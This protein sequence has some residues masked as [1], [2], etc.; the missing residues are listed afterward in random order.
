MY[1]HA[2]ACNRKG[3]KSSCIIQV[4]ACRWLQSQV[5]GDRLDLSCIGMQPK[6]QQVVMHTLAACW[7]ASGIHSCM[8]ALPRGTAPWL[9]ATARAH[10]CRMIA[11]FGRADQLGHWARCRV[12]QGSGVHYAEPGRFPVTRIQTPQPPAQLQ[13]PKLHPV[14]QSPNP[15]P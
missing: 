3:S 4:F 10:A 11:A 2:L 7:R 9:R 13:H 5:L 15:R 6:G 12:F 1:I 8:G 14:N